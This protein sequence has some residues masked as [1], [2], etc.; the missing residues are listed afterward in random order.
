MNQI[1]GG[2]GVRFGIRAPGALGTGQVG[3]L[4]PLCWSMPMGT[5]GGD[6]AIV[7]ALSILQVEMLAL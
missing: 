4:A 3:L 7:K 1:Q 5:V 6:E 2:P